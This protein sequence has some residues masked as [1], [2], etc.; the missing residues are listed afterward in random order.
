M[1]FRNLFF[2]TKDTEV[3]ELYKTLDKVFKRINSFDFDYEKDEDEAKKNYCSV[4]SLDPYR[5][6]RIELPLAESY[7]LKISM[8][9][10]VTWLLDKIFASNLDPIAITP[11]DTD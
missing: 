3:T 4:E 11:G 1:K 7:N 2:L 9:R 6:N 8:D 10:A 5:K